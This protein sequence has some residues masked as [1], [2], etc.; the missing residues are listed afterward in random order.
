[1]LCVNQPLVLN[2]SVLWCILQGSFG[3]TLAKE[4]A[5]FLKVPVSEL[6]LDHVRSCVII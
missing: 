6:V 3:R 1:M 5:Q 2:I 4:I